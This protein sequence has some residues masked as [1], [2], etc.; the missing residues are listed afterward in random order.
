MGDIFSDS[1]RQFFAMFVAPRR[2]IRVI[3]D[4]HPTDPGKNVWALALTFMALSVSAN[5]LARAHGASPLLDFSLM[6]VL[7]LVLICLWLFIFAWALKTT[8][9]WTKGEGTFSEIMAVCAWTM[10]PAILLNAF[11]IPL[12]LTVQNAVPFSEHAEDMSLW[13]HC[14]TWGLAGIEVVIWAWQLVI[15]SRALAEV[16]KYR[17]SWK[18]L[19]NA[20]LPF[21]VFL[22]MAITFFIA[23]SWVVY[24]LKGVGVI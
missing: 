22:F 3:V 8:G 11:E 1:I 9:K 19:G 13:A 20:I 23:V 24:T 4:A 2:T 21:G 17:S 7:G 16:Q 5:F 10:G 18:G 12:L 14:V 15:F 6:M